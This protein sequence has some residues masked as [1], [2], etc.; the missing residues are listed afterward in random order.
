MQGSYLALLAFKL[1]EQHYK[2]TSKP[3]F[4]QVALQEFLEE[5]IAQQQEEI[6]AEN[7]KMLTQL[8]REMLNQIG[9]W[10]Q[11][12]QAAATV[13]PV[14]VEGLEAGSLKVVSRGEEGGQPKDVRP[15]PPPADHPGGDHPGGEGE[16]AEEEEADEPLYIEDAL[17]LPAADLNKIYAFVRQ[18]HELHPNTA[19]DAKIATVQQMLAGWVFAGEGTNDRHKEAPWTTLPSTTMQGGTPWKPAVLNYLTKLELIPPPHDEDIDY[20]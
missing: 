9:G 6:L 19:Y 1:I 14:D 13:Q 17:A 2:L 4:D 5:R 7:K 16:E 11:N 8:G 10:L 20:E 18:I 3:E 12:F 15:G